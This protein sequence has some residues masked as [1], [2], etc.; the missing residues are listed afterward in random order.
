MNAISEQ[1]IVHLLQSR[2]LVR[3]LGVERECLDSGEV[4]FEEPAK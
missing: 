1:L 3:E 4:A 2:I